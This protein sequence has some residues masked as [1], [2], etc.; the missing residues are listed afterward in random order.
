VEMCIRDRRDEGN[1]GGVQTV[2]REE[3]IAA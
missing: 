2:C 3:R 1:I